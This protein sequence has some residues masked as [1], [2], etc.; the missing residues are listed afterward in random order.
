MGFQNIQNGMAACLRNDAE[1]HF[2]KSACIL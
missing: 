1:G 2:K